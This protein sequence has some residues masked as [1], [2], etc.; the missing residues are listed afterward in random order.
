M[1][2]PLNGFAPGGRPMPPGLNPQNV[3]GV[4]LDRLVRKEVSLGVIRERL[5]PQEHIGLAQIAPFLN[6]ATDDVIFD[7]IKQG[8]SDGLAPARAEDAEAELAQKDIGIYGQGRASVVDWSL[9]DRYTA[10]DV[11]KYR[12]ALF[13]QAQANGVDSGAIPLNFVGSTVADFETRLAVHDAL[14]RRKLDN[15]IE[16]MIMTAMETGQ[17]VYNDGKIKFTVDYGRPAN[18]QD[19]A[20]TGAMW[21]AGVDHDPIGDFIAFNQFMYD[22][23]GVR[24]YKAITSLK[25]MN[26]MWK[27]NRFAALTGLAIPSGGTGGSATSGPVDPNYLLAGWGPQAAQEVVERATGVKFT[28]YDSVY[29][30]RPLGGTIWTQ[31]RFLSDNKIYFYP[32]DSD[33]GEIDGTQIGFAKTLTAPH[34]EGAWQPGYYEW[35]ESKIDPWVQ[36]R[37]SGIKAFP[38][39]PYMEY[40]YTMQVLADDTTAFDGESPDGTY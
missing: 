5:W 1:N 27:S 32:N 16:W 30:T 23:Y 7:Y 24:L 15:R 29:R 17:I 33:L 22:H 37:G 6:V 39:F 25:V 19:Q 28:I 21:D 36:I 12:E 2:W 9:K 8:Y 4:G 11:S 20:P 38:V 26:A 14:R 3:A 31:N 34:P 13:L 35:E 10:S 40:T 18:Q